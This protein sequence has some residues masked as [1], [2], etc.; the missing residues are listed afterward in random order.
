MS[1]HLSVDGVIE[2]S[3]SLSLINDAAVNLDDQKSLQIL[4]SFLSDTYPES[5]V[6]GPYGEYSFN[7]LG[8]FIM[9]CYWQN[10]V[11]RG[12]R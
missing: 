5:G 10:K 3:H 9:L 2:Y 6:I 4:I 8:N 7:F 12:G 1:I 11:C